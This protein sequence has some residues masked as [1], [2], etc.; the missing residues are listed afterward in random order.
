MYI[1]LPSGNEGNRISIGIEFQEFWSGSSLIKSV[2]CGCWLRMVCKDSWSVSG[3]FWR[4]KQLL[5][6]IFVTLLTKPNSRQNRFVLAKTILIYEIISDILQKCWTK[7]KKT[8]PHSLTDG[9]N[10]SNKLKA[11]YE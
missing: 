1:H 10:Q 9:I 11:F 3:V 5:Y 4:K 7:I 8:I 2:D 6:F